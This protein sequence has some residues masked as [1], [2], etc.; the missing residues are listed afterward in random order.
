MLQKH[1]NTYFIIRNESWKCLAQFSS[2]YQKKGNNPK[3]CA[4][5]TLLPPQK[6]HQLF[7]TLIF[8]V[9]ELATVSTIYI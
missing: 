7:Y 2:G 6:H 4:E 8:P 1:K 5:M 3:K 9:T